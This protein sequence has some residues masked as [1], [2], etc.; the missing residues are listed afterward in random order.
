[1]CVCECAYFCVCTCVCACTCELLPLA[2][3]V[4]QP[5]RP[6][7]EVQYETHGGVGHLLN[8]VTRHVTNRYAWKR[9]AHIISDHLYVYLILC[10]KYYMTTLRVKIKSKS[11]IIVT[12]TL[13]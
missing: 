5:V 7:V 10:K 1:M 2:H 6:S 4:G 3:H 9:T 12:M 11:G 8:A 13:G